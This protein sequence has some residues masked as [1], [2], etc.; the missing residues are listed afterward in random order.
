VDLIWIGLK[1]NYTA[2][3]NTPRVLIVDHVVF[4]SLLLDQLI[5]K[6][7]IEA[8]EAISGALGMGFETQNKYKIKNS[9]GQVSRKT[10][11]CGHFLLRDNVAY[12]FISTQFY[13]FTL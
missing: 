8:L 9:L 10:T 6:Q 2:S 11:I 1:P 13:L 12:G 3:S 4:V 7:K 5:V